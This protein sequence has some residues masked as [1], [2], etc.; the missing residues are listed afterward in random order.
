MVIYQIHK[1]SGQYEDFT[2]VIVGSYLKKER[3]EEEK[4]NFET[5]K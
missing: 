3:A 1:Y 5:K 2:D 4:V